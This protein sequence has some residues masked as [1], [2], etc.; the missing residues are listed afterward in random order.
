MQIFILGAVLIGLTVLLGFIV[1]RTVA[2]IRARRPLL[3]IGPV[4]WQAPVRPV[5]AQAAPEPPLE[6]ADVSG[7][8]R[9]TPASPM[10]LPQP[11][12]A[13]PRERARKLVSVSELARAAAQP[14]IVA[15]G[16]YAGIEA[17]LEA[18]FGALCDGTINPDAYLAR[19]DEE[20]AGVQ[21]IQA[22]LGPLAADALHAEVADAIAALQWCREWAQQHAANHRSA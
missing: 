12:T 19:I 18:S 10:P 15:A 7:F 13:A 14:P 6:R 1:I 22:N 4:Q 17:R 20:F 9:A 5:T 2:M 11:P 8:G 16:F 3:A 21:R